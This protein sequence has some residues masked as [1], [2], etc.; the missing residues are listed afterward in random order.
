VKLF[1]AKTPVKKPKMTDQDRVA[2]ANEPKLGFEF[3]KRSKG[4]FPKT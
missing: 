4:V 1:K 2:H 3:G